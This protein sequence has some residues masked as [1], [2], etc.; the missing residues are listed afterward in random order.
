MAF[1]SPSV[2]PPT[3]S[4][5]PSVYFGGITWS[6]N[7]PFYLKEIDGLDMPQV[8]SGDPDAPRQ[9]GQYV[10]LDLL[11]GRDITLKFDV[12]P[13]FGAYLNLSTALAYLR[14][15]LTPTMTTEN[16]LFVQLPLGAGGS[17][18]ATQF[19]AMVRPRRRST[20]VDIPYV[21]GQLAQNLSVQFHATD[22]TLYAAGTLNPSVNVPAP[23][24]GF[25]FPLSF[26]L[27]FGGGTQVGTISATNSGDLPCFP[28]FVVTG[29][30]TYPT[31]SNASLTN[32]PYIQF[33]ITLNAG[34]QLVI[35]T[36]PKYRSVT[37]YTSGS[38]SGSTRLAT[39]S[40]NSTWFPLQAGSN[41]IE[42]STLDTQS[43]AGYL[44]MEWSSAYSAA[45]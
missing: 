21:Y 5:F 6:G 44:N 10:G 4:I 38:T 42:F 45:A 9:H 30:C 17:N 39:L 29:P 1:P 12:G 14:S 20:T 33:Q 32:S 24:G 7:G 19:A 22:P 15:A 23:L 36:D 28:I 26:P 31:I 16:P 43:V 8:R 37:Y 34:D 27:S 25:S 41:L 2:T 13:P 11:S 35:N 3:F 40:Q 18:G